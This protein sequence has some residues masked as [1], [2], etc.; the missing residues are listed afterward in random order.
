M[1]CDLLHIQSQISKGNEKAFAELYSLF[2]RKLYF[3]AKAI[4]RSSEMAEEVVEDVFVKLWS[5]RHYIST[6]SNLA[7]YL[8]VA[9]KNRSL[10]VVSKKTEALIGS[11]FDELEIELVH[12]AIDPYSLLVTSEMM[13]KMR[14]AIETLPPRCKMIFKLVREDGLKY[15]EVSEILNISINTIDVQMAI[16]VKKICMAMQGT[17]I[18]NFNLQKAR[19]SKKDQ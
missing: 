18:T 8:Y 5:N 13:E 3:F 11:P 14:Q 19:S 2:K 10:N 16:A 7:V 9:V 12:P 4:T 1:S 15:K 17:G 6:I